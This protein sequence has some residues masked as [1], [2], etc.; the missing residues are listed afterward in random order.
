MPKKGYGRSSRPRRRQVA[1]GLTGS[2]KYRQTKTNPQAERGALFQFGRRFLMDINFCEA[3]IL[4]IQREAG[5]SDAA[6][7]LA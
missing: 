3:L 4:A 1:E 7:F 5:D 2:V 6:S